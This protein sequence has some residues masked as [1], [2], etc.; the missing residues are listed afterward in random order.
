MKLLSLRKVVVAAVV[1][2]GVLACG[3]AAA[4][5]SQSYVQRGLLA[6]WDG[7]DNVGVG[8]HDPS[9][10]CWADLTGNGHNLTNFIAGLSWNGDSLQMPT[11]AYGLAATFA[12]S[13]DL[14]LDDY[15]S[16]EIVY[17]QHVKR[18]R[19]VVFGFGNFKGLSLNADLGTLTVH[20][21]TGGSWTGVSSLNEI[22]SVFV[23]YDS[24][25]ATTAESVE[26]DGV[27]LTVNSGTV[28]WGQQT[29][30]IGLYNSTSRYMNG[31][32]YAI[33]LYTRKLTPEERAWN[34]AVDALRFVKTSD[35]SLVVSCD[36]LA[37]GTPQPDYGVHTI[38]TETVNCSVDSE[39]KDEQAGIS[40]TSL[41]Y[42]IYDRDPETNA[43][44]FREASPDTS[45]TV[46][47][48]GTPV[49]IEWRWQVSV[50]P[51][52]TMTGSGTVTAC[53]WT[54]LGDVIELTATPA[55]GFAFGHWSGDLPRGVDAF[56]PNLKF[57]AAANT[58]SIVAHFLPVVYVE[59]DGADTNGGLSREDAFA[60][61]QKALDSPEP[62]FVKVGP[63][64]YEISSAILVDTDSTIEGSTDG[65][66]DPVS[67]F[68]ITAGGGAVCALRSENARVSHL[69][70]T[71]RGKKYGRGALLQRGGLLD[72][73]VITNCI[74]SVSSDN[75]VVVD[76]K[77]GGVCLY[78]GGV[79]RNCRV[80][81]CQTSGFGT[82]SGGGLA[83]VGDGLVES[84]SFSKC[85]A[86]SSNNK[87][88]GG[89][90]YLLRGGTVRNSLFSRCY[91]QAPTGDDATGLH[92]VGGRVENCTLAGSYHTSSL[93]APAVSLQGG[94]VVNSIIWGNYNKSKTGTGIVCT[95]GSV[96]HC[97]CEEPIEGEGNLTDNPAFLDAEHDDYR[98]GYSPCVDKGADLQWHFGA[99]DL[100]GDDRVIGT[101]VDLGCYEFRPTGISVSLT[102]KS[103]GKADCSSVEFQA[104][105]VGAEPSKSDF[106]WVVAGKDGF[107]L[108]TNELALA[109]LD[110]DLPAGSY[111]VTVSVDDGTSSGA[112]SWP[113]V[114]IVKSSNTYVSLQGAGVPPYAD[115]SNATNDVFAALE[116]TADGG[117]VHL[118][119]GHYYLPRSLI[120]SRNVRILGERGADGVQIFATQEQ[121]FPMVLLGHADAVLEGI[122]LDGRNKMGIQMTLNK[123][124]A[125]ISSN[126]G[127]VTNCI[128]NQIV[129]NDNG[130][131]FR[132]EGGRVV[133]SVI[134]GCKAHSAF[135]GT[136][137]GGCAIAGGVVEHCVI[138]NNVSGDVEGNRAG[139]VYISSGRLVNSIVADNVC[140]S[141]CGG[142]YNDGGEVINCLVYGNKSAGSGTGIYQTDTGRTV[143]TT[144][145]DNHSAGDEVSAAFLVSGTGLA[146]NCIVWGNDGVASQILKED[147]GAEV[148]NNCTDDPS[149]A[150]RERRNYHLTARSKNCIDCG[151]DSVWGEELERA[152]DFDGGPRRLNRHV[153]IGCYEKRM[154]G[155]V[156]FLQ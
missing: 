109:K 118:D 13:V 76:N 9:A 5:T 29:S 16:Y 78:G 116:M 98:I 17:Q 86:N 14:G 88:Y 93:S 33:R 52:V 95:G 94:A 61:V 38:D 75:L 110:L 36:T 89:G 64:V 23:T 7:I 146:K 117:T 47:R 122:T 92:L 137:G 25:L 51:A 103:D 126:G 70:M 152:T 114:V 3:S 83:I 53:P 150:D 138:T 81:G 99:K 104:E 105:I 49:E 97:T 6:Q 44:V 106:S 57:A 134:R 121:G 62:R 19:A 141:I 73:C 34:R 142:I 140:S 4:Y 28:T 39:W 10:V 80:D 96:A 65:N 115:F 30:G 58:R 50:K 43:R 135:S 71:S 111:D 143:N 15:V 67:V 147:E 59:K 139:G 119:D 133:D 125:Y 101:A 123:S 41:G 1:A 113:D 112:K 100:A 107:R 22:H 153:D 120:L 69:A 129:A 151:D 42:A 149:F 40:A 66:G 77:G 60:T 145:V 124:G 144:V 85:C 82:F 27:P 108:E 21:K 35:D 128:F 84:C 131:A 156:L 72:H 55:E 46:Q 68:A 63:G 87:N 31:R 90:A 91:V 56:D 32:I 37:C 24:G 45:V 79:M 132:A 148:G 2:A 26:L 48:T 12:G 127:M 155:L 102:V 74:C 154:R 8:Q 136:R 54:R 11:T 130:A 20:N 18:D